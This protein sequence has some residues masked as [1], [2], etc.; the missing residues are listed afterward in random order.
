MYVKT[1]S[2]DNGDT[3]VPG[4][5]GV[6]PE[7]VVEMEGS[8]LGVG[9]TGDGVTVGFDI[10]AGSVACMGVGVGAGTSVG[11]GVVVTLVVGNNSGVGKGV[12]VDVKVDTGSI[13]EGNRS[14][15]SDM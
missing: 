5:T 12:K 3:D 1:V 8:W 10:D 15:L 6:S 14:I 9:D 2:A 4:I 7:R 11:I 13:A